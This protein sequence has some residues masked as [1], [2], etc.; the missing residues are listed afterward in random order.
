MGLIRALYSRPQARVHLQGCYSNPI[1]I[2]KGT[3][4]GCPLSPLIFALAIETPAVAIRENPNIKGVTCGLQTHKCGLY[5]DNILLFFTFITSLPNLC[6]TL[7]AF[8]GISGLQVNYSKSLAMNVSLQPNMVN[9]LQNS[10]P[11]E[12]NEKSIKYL[13]INLTPKTESLYNSNYLLMFRKLEVDLKAWSKHTLSWIG[14][15]NSVKKTLLP[16][17]LYLFRSLP[18]QI[19]RAHIRAFQSKILKFIW[20][21]GGYRLPQSILYCHRKRG[22]LDLPKLLQYYFAARLA[23]IS[24]IYS[25]YE[26]PD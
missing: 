14:Q 7:D 10:F 18:I 15:I 19:N 23:Q 8:A 13:G 2:E 11:F 4:Q 20:G 16:K 1:L 6:Q 9:L 24:I 17:L 26:K 25:R 5:A 12:W 21:K 22:G 3:R